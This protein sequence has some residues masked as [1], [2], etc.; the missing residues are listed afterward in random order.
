MALIAAHAKNAIF[1]AGDALRRA[2][3]GSYAHG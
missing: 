2:L 3:L 1:K